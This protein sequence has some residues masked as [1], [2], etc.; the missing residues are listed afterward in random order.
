MYV[1]LP[2]SVHAALRLN[3][4]GVGQLFVAHPTSLV[5]V[6][7]GLWPISGMRTCCYLVNACTL[8]PTRTL[9]L[10]WEGDVC[11]RACV[12]VCMQLCMLVCMQVC[13]VYTMCIYIYTYTYVCIYVF[14]YVCRCLC[15][16]LR[17]C[18]P[19][20]PSARPS[21]CMYIYIHTCKY[22]HMYSPCICTCTYTDMY[23]HI[24]ICM[25]VQN[26]IATRRRGTQR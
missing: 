15:L 24:H 18:L 26:F 25:D 11:V 17:L 9:G 7:S 16:C 21:A 3:L 10:K 14:L 5:W 20:C 19:V 6:H 4:Q 23:I 22:A 8:R 13:I 1:R 2:W 12:S